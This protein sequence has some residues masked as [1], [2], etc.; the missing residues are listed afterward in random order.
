MNYKYG[1][2]ELQESDIVKIAKR[3]QN[4]TA[5]AVLSPEEQGLIDDYRLMDRKSQLKVLKYVARL[6]DAKFDVE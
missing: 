4:S 3:I 6:L 5:P 2:Y 1:N